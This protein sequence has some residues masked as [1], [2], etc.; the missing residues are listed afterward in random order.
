MSNDLNNLSRTSPY[1]NA[2]T[3][4]P[5][6]REVLKHHMYKNDRMRMKSPTNSFIDLV[7]HNPGQSKVQKK[8]LY[9]KFKSKKIRAIY[10]KRVTMQINDKVEESEV[11]ANKQ[12][13]GNDD[14]D[15]Q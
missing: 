8:S 2:N 1:N 12:D 11:Q 9:D 10:G 13:E 14:E 3:N 7:T 5:M 6:F 4:I 15:I